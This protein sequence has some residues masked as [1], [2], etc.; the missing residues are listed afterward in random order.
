MAKAL[1]GKAE[2][3]KGELKACI[4]PNQWQCLCNC[5]GSQKRIEAGK[6]VA[7][8]CKIQ[9]PSGGSQKRIEGITMSKTSN[10]G[11]VSTCEDLKRELKEN[12]LDLRCNHW[13][14]REDLKGELVGLPLV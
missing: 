13:I 10:I 9:P 2:D 11:F 3:L 7:I 14:E 12:V 6:G 5:R 1:S 4:P 8:Q